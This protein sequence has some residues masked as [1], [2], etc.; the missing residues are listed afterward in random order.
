[1]YTIEA[2]IRNRKTCLCL[3]FKNSDDYCVINCKKELTV[4]ECHKKLRLHPMITEE[5]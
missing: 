1:M 3:P 5:L 2:N 4:N